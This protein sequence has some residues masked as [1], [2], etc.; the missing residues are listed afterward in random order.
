MEVWKE[1]V[2]HFKHY[3]IKFLSMDWNCSSQKIYLKLRVWSS[4]ESL[5]SKSWWQIT[6][7]WDEGLNTAD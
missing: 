4:D 6:K 5:G 1:E 2:K 3:D 7:E